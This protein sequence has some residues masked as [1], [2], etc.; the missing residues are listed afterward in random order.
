MLSRSRAT[1]ERQGALSWLPSVGRQLKFACKEW[2]KSALA[3]PNKRCSVSLEL[4]K[5]IRYNQNLGVNFQF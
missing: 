3:V 2:E 4:E 1:S 5:G